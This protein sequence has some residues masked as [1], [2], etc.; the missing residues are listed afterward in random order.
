MFLS[1]DYTTTITRVSRNTRRESPVVTADG[2]TIHSR[3]EYLSRTTTRGH[4]LT[5]TDRVLSSSSNYDTEPSPRK[6][7]TYSHVAQVCLHLTL[8]WW[9]AHSCLREGVSSHIVRRPIHWRRGI[10]KYMPFQKSALSP[11]WGEVS[12]LKGSHS[13]FRIYKS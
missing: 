11:T 4:H 1:K 5:T 12:S 9:T 3:T 2:S 8:R 7:F 6:W 10:T 13:Y